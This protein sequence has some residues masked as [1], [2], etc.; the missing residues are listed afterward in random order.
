MLWNRGGVCAFKHTGSG[1]DQ[2]QQQTFFSLMLS[3][4]RTKFIAWSVMQT[5]HQK[6]IHVVRVVS[7]HSRGLYE[8]FSHVLGTNRGFVSKILE[9][10]PGFF[11]FQNSPDRIK[12]AGYDY[13]SSG[14]VGQMAESFIPVQ[15]PTNLL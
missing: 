13:Q 4:V 3:F 2:Q 12:V 14:V 5:S 1:R 15:S 6:T 8:G 9:Y 7:I 11:F 10:F